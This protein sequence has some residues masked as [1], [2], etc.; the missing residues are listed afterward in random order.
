[1]HSRT[2]SRNYRNLDSR[3]RLNHA[4]YDNAGNQTLQIVAPSTRTTYTWNDDNRQTRVQATGVDLTA[5]YRYDGLRYEKAASGTTTRFVFDGANYLLETNTAGIVQ[6]TYTGEPQTYG[7]LISRRAS[8]A[9][10]YYHFD[11]LGST[12]ILTNSSQTSTD[13]YTYDAWGVPTVTI[14]SAVNPFR[15]V[16]GVGYLLPTELWSQFWPN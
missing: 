1:M 7:K 9:T 16:G 4:R 10:R 13:L 6:A 12:R 2:N 15:W 11:A 14:G 5:T 8:G 3:P